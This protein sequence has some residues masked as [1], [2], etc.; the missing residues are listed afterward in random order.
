MHQYQFVVPDGAEDMLQRMA[1]QFVQGP[2]TPA[3]V[4]LKRMGAA[5]EGMLSFPM[6]GWTLAVDLPAYEPAIRRLLDGMDEAVA[7]AG[8]RVYLAKDARLRPELMTAM[9]P[10][11]EEW[12]AV[13]AGV[14]PEHRF[15]SDLAE[16]LGLVRPR[17][18]R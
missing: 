7:A 17:G 13:K 8:G 10:R 14:D 11:L 16:R 9:Y 2:V 15:R 3:L 4:V 12:R 5:G 6:T 1:A 18:V